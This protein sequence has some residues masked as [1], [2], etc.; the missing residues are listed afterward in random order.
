MQLA[1]L[2]HRDHQ[3][4]QDRLGQQGRKV[5]QVIKAHLAHLASAEEVSVLKELQDGQVETSRLSSRDAM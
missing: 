4:A 2:V 5:L 3:V 1:P